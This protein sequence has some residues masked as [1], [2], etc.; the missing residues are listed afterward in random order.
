MYGTKITKV[1]KGVLMSKKLSI[2]VSVIYSPEYGAI[3]EGS[4]YDIISRD[5]A[6][7]TA[8]TEVKRR[9]KV[10]IPSSSDCSVIIGHKIITRK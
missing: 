8:V 1:R 6:I 3:A 5:E 2:S 9:I 10:N 7:E 4:I